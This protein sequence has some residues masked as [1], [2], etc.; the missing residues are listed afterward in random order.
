MTAPSSAPLAERAAVAISD[1]IHYVDRGTGLPRHLP[2][3]TI[4]DPIFASGDPGDVASFTRVVGYNHT[5]DSAIWTGHYLAAEAF[6]Y[7]VT[8]SA[9]ALRNVRQALDGLDALASLT[10]AAQPGP[11]ARFVLPS[12][13]PFMA[14]IRAIEAR[15]R[16]YPGV[17]RGE[18]V[19]W[20]GN[21]SR[22]QYSGAFFG[23][24]VAYDMLDGGRAEDAAPRAHAAEIITRLLAFLV[25]TGGNVVMPD[26]HVSTSFLARPD[27]QLALL[28]IGRHV[29]PDRFEGA[30]TSL[31]KRVAGAVPVPIAA[32]CTEPHKSYYKFNLDHVNLYALIRLEP[33][34][35]SYRKTYLHALTI[36]R[37]CTGAHGNAHF[38][39]IAR[40][41]LGPD[42]GPNGASDAAIAEGLRRWL[43][44]QR[45]DFAVD[46]TGKY[47]ACGD[48][49][50]C[51]PVPVEERPNTDF[52]WQRSPFLL[53]SGGE[54]T[55]AT[56]GI[57]YIL[58]Y[59]M[60]R[61]HGIAVDEPEV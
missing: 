15:H 30:Y 12:A 45:R 43:R 49:R 52:L 17:L 53:A 7:R 51:E 54:G 16:F 31:R 32:E 6:R 36:L 21:T 10:G 55:V 57:D 56:P 47:A 41:L 3:G 5:G 11:L 23:L 29:N 26:G 39:V 59:W 48:N 8:G 1:D 25:H 44:R 60:A 34:S 4:A 38:D 58:P 20:I 61:F 46:L 18:P 42:A 35:S 40:A 13:S 19:E 22:D 28:Q 2:Y 9:T 37:A 27:Q 33:P 14:G 50:A 24:G